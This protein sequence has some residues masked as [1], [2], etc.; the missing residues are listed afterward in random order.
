MI[1]PNSPPYY[2]LTIPVCNDYKYI[3][4]Y[5]KNTLRIRGFYE[6]LS[7]YKESL[8]KIHWKRICSEL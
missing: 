2:F 1:I 6:F 4:I 7:T 5:Y 3:D 8:S